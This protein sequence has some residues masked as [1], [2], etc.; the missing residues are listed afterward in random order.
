MHDVDLVQSF[1]ATAQLQQVT[2]SRQ[3]VCVCERGKEQGKNGSVP[4]RGRAW[5]V[6]G[7]W[8]DSL[9]D[10]RPYCFFRE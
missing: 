7:P 8:D 4:L 3:R 6:E 2:V 5:F 1:K 10:L 9:F